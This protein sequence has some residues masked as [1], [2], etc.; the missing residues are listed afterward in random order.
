VAFLLTVLLVTRPPGTSGV[1]RDGPFRLGRRVWTTNGVSGRDG[2]EDRRDLIGEILEGPDVGNPEA[3]S[4]LLGHTATR[5]GRS[6]GRYRRAIAWQTY[7]A[8]HSPLITI[9]SISFVGLHT[10]TLATCI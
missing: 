5:P 4:R 3:A 6:H 8:W 9:F 7:R 10:V 1:V 2:G